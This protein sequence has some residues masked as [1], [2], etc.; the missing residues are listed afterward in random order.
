MRAAPY[1]QGGLGSKSRIRGEGLS[2]QV[3]L[4]GSDMA[5]PAAGRG[6]GSLFKYQQRHTLPRVRQL[7]C[8]ASN[9]NMPLL[10]TEGWDAMWDLLPA[11]EMFLGKSFPSRS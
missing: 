5:Q 10:L 8:S 4:Q 3:I 6:R 1:L 11:Q 2:K 7:I 9:N